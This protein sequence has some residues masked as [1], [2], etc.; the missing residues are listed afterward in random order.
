MMAHSSSA[1]RDHL[2]SL[3]AALNIG[4]AGAGKWLGSTL[5]GLLSLPLGVAADSAAA[6][7]ATFAIVGLVLLGSI[8]PLLRVPARPPQPPAA[9]AQTATPAEPAEATGAAAISRLS[10]LLARLIAPLSRRLRQPWRSVAADPLPL[11]LLLL[12]PLLI[13]CGAALLIPYLNIFLSERY[14]AG[15]TELGF[16]LAA[17]DIAAGLAMLAAPLLSARLGKIGAIVLTQLLSIPF[18]LLSGFAPGLLIAGG[19]LV[20][21][22]GLFNLGVPLYDAFAMERSPPAARPIVIGLV[23]GAYAAGYLLAPAISTRVQQFYGFAPLFVA[24]ASFYVL[25]A[26]L[27]FAFFGRGSGA[28]ARAS[29]A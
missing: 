17:G 7:R 22:F 2:F 9:E 18:L 20:M 10:A 6:Y 29:E 15:N 3:N 4:V 23:N 28:V 1:E 16:I 13:S 24:T 11:L 19:A 14:D 8:L 21:R 5:P 12:P 26:L 27:M 25:A